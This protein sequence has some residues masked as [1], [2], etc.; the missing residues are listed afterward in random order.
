MLTHCQLAPGAPKY[1]ILQENVF[2]S[3]AC[4]MVAILFR[5]QRAKRLSPLYQLT[6]VPY[7][8]LFE[9][10]F[11]CDKNGSPSHTSQHDIKTSFVTELCVI[12]NQ[13]TSTCSIVGHS[14]NM[15]LALKFL[16]VRLTF[17]VIRWID[18]IASIFG[19]KIFKVD[20]DHILKGLSPE[21]VA[22]ATSPAVARP[23][24]LMVKGF[25]KDTFLGAAW[26]FS[27]IKIH[28]DILQKRVSIQKALRDFPDVV[29]VGLNID[30]FN[31]ALTKWPLLNLLF[32]GIF[33]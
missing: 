26:R 28:Q 32:P 27:M 29:Q 30:I 17:T 33:A 10:H 9:P 2:A 7:D 21:E 3:V 14:V 20:M 31:E 18:C 24:S 1:K 12:P 5:P 11:L 25:E 15:V 16:V 6:P 4:K 23:L 8:T 19:Y 13:F 22:E